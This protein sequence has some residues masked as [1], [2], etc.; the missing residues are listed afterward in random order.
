[1]VDTEMHAAVQRIPVASLNCD[2]M[3]PRI[4]EKV[5]SP[6]D[7]IRAIFRADPEKQLELA[8]DIA[9]NGLM[10]FISLYVA[11][12]TDGQYL[13]LEGNRRTAAMKA[14]HSPEIVDDILTPSQRKRLSVA[15]RLKNVPDQVYCVLASDKATVD[16][17]IQRRHTPGQG[18]AG[19]VSW[20]PLQVARYRARALGE[21]DPTLFMLELVIEHGHLE[22]SIIDG[23]DTSF[24][25]TNLERFVESPRARRILGIDLVKADSSPPSVQFL[26]PVD[27]VVPVWEELVRRVAGK[28]KVQEIKT[29]EQQVAYALALGESLLPRPDVMSEEY[30]REILPYFQGEKATAPAESQPVEVGGDVD[31]ELSGASATLSEASEN[32]DTKVQDAAQPSEPAQA[33]VST[34]AKTRTKLVPDGFSFAHVRPARVLEIFD[35]LRKL[36]VGSYRNSAAVLFRVFVELSVDVLQNEQ[37]FYVP[38]D[39][40]ATWNRVPLDKKLTKAIEWLEEGGHIKADHALAAKKAFSAQPLKESSVTILN[41]FV[42]NSAMFPDPIGL[43]TAWDNVQPFLETLWNIRPKPTED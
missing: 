33:K 26:G 20:G 8:E 2:P 14:L 27:A 5:S 16:M 43:K 19:L 12:R 4:V 9:A 25:F 18:G 28:L 38:P 32:A 6:R 37:A 35:E 3:N 22:R 42:H 10:P 1:M 39:Q 36:P 21:M 41:G 15:A 40:K 29:V 13:V 24:N 31:V 7:A 34:A 11:A 23:L 17:W 30:Q